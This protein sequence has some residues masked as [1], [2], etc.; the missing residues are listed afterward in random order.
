[1]SYKDKFTENQKTRTTEQIQKGKHFLM[2]E[3]FPAERRDRFI[4]RGKKVIVECQKHD[5]YQ[6]AI[7]WLL[8]VAEEY[9]ELGQGVGEKG[10]E[11]TGNIINVPRFLLVSNRP[12]TLFQDPALR[13]AVS[14]L[15]QLLE[16]FANGQTMHLI[17]DSIDALNDDARRDEEFRAWFKRLNIFIRKVCRFIVCSCTS[18]T[19]RSYCW[20]PAM[21]LRTTAV[22]RA[23]K[24]ASLAGNSGIRSTG[25]TLTLYSTPLANG[26][27]PWA[28]TH[29]TSGLGRTGRG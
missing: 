15:R 7:K 24:S 8:S 23:K 25:H 28:K 9:L 29:S 3:Y 4:F 6:D 21:S 14:E 2:D 20:S 19:L 1:M 10:K 5:D 11:R 17:F 16:R 27:P 26:F 18:M 12:L 22:V 13:H